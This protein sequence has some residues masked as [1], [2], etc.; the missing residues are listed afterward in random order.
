VEEHLFG[1][2]IQLS[3]ALRFLSK[4][5]PHKPANIIIL[6]STMENSR[7]YRIFSKKYIP[8]SRVSTSVSRK[9]SV[10]P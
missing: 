9:Y 3:Y 2:K 5:K 1:A 4:A 6:D 7:G 10:H 8:L